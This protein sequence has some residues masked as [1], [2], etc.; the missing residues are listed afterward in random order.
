MTT[1]Q[2]DM[3]SF[4]GLRRLLA[5]L[6]APGGCPWDREQTHQ[7]L[8]KTLL[9]E[10]YEALD[11]L[12]RQDARGLGE[13]LGDLL[14][15]VAFHCQIAE[16]LGEFTYAQVFRQLNEKLVRRHPH[17]FGDATATT[18]KEVEEQWEALKEKERAGRESL[19]DGVSPSMPAL[20]YAQVIS[21]RAVRAGFEWEAFKDVTA[22]VME[23]LGEL[24]NAATP[25]EREAELG[26]VLFTVVNVARWMGLD[27]ESA[28]RG[29]TQR[30]GRRFRHMEQASHERGVAFTQL[31]LA[32]KE[33]LWQEA[34]RA[35]REG[36]KDAGDS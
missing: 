7:S 28:L 5:R 17:V 22:K 10:C 3:D 14:L 24:E 6:R 20:A 36:G 2:P 8:R 15:Q 11:A 18:A 29:A 9:E 27:A 21:Q 31:P 26:D 34:K 35:L 33:Q 19:L 16:E 25:E 13:E 4:E 32:E 1:S 30:F 12:D 23:E